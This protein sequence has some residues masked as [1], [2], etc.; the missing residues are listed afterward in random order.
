MQRIGKSNTGGTWGKPNGRPA[1]HHAAHLQHLLSTMTRS[2][3]KTWGPGGSTQSP[4]Y[5]SPHDHGKEVRRP[6]RERRET[7]MYFHF[8]SVPVLPKPKPM[9]GEEERPPLSLYC[10]LQQPTPQHAPQPMSQLTAHEGGTNHSQV[11]TSIAI[12]DC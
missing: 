9:I 5:P 12:Y 4:P 3:Q 8:S 10:T 2:S 1:H 6:A 11:P 7:K